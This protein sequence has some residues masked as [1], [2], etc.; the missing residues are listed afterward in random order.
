MAQ[1]NLIGANPYF[2]HSFLFTQVISPGVDLK[3]TD[4]LD[5][6]VDGFFITVE[7]D[8]YLCI[9]PL[10]QSTPIKKYFSSTGISNILVK[11]IVGSVENTAT[12]VFICS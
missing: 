4:Y 3:T 8:G 6:G 12:G 11:K 10:E 7:G 2:K 5:K 1:N 9:I